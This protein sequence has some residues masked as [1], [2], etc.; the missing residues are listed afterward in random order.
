YLHEDGYTTN[1]I[2]GCTQPRRVAAMSV[3]KRVSEE[4]ETELGD[5][6]GYAIRFE[7]ITGVNTVIKA[8]WTLKYLDKYRVIVMDEAHER[9]LNTD[10]LFG[11]LK[12]VVA[13]RRDFKLIITSAT[14]NA[15]KFSDFFGSAPIFDIPGRTFPVQIMYSKSPCEDYVEAAV[16]QAMTIHAQVVRV[17]Y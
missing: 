2:V 4:M 7:D 14:L 16:K 15:K 8:S 6:V 9:S 17:T 3:T 1:G 11:I 13:R 12:K 5:L 10:V